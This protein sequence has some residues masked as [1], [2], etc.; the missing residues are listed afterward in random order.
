VT[1]NVFPC[2]TTTCT[3]FQGPVEPVPADVAHN[4]VGVDPRFEAEDPRVSLD[5]NLDS[6][7][8]AYALGFQAIA[9][10][11]GNAVSE[12]LKCDAPIFCKRDAQSSQII[13]GALGNAYLI[14][15]LRLLAAVQNEGKQIMRL[16]V[17]D[18]YAAEGMY[19]FKKSLGQHFLKDEGICKQIIA[20]LQENTF[21][22]L[23][24]V[25][26]GGG[27]LTKYIIKII[28]C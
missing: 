28:S 16:L 8:P 14:N 24:E 26:P 25:G 22:N 9:D 1:A 23:V 3:F 4:L 19:T 10:L 21:Q 12:V 7:S 15:A 18:K 20:S 5:F 2:N 13:Q 17:S 27:A 6:D 11:V